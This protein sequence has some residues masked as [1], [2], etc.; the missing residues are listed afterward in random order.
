MK[1][2]SRNLVH[3]HWDPALEST[4]RTPGPSFLR[5]H[6]WDPW[7]YQVLDSRHNE[8]LSSPTDAADRHP[9]TTVS[10]S[11]LVHQINLNRNTARERGVR[12]Y[13]VSIPGFLNTPGMKPS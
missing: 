4:D 1:Q 8:N 2:R 3:N 5:H 11:D 9:P 13:I 7:S 10:L 12:T 6:Q